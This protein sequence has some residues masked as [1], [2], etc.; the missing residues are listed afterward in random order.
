MNDERRQAP[1]VPDDFDVPRSL[2]CAGMRLRPLDVEHND[3][4]YAAWTSS[5]AHIQ[6]TPGFVG[7]TWPHPMSLADNL[8]DLA[9]HAADFAARRGFT[10]TVLDRNDDV[11]GCVYIYPPRDA[12]HD[13][14]VTSWVRASH[15]AL[16]RAL[17]ECVAD[18]L[19]RAWPFRKV[20]YARRD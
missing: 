1:L 9:K 12:A 4:D 2:D 11:V 6:A 8:G 10:F 14:R 3:R 13:A 5:M 17:Y 16:D 19:V 15:A 7:E 18:W 20:D